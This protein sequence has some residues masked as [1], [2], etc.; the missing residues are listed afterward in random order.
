MAGLT[1]VKVEISYF[2]PSLLC[3]RGEV[4]N[5]GRSRHRAS[6]QGDWEGCSTA[7]HGWWGKA[8]F[9]KED[10]IIVKLK[11]N[12]WCF[13]YCCAAPPRVMFLSLMWLVLYGVPFLF[14]F[15]LLFS[16]FLD[17]FLCLFLLCCTVLLTAISRDLLA[18]SYDTNGYI[19]IQNFLYFLCL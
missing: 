13:I 14:S 6:A 3:L 4:L 5:W 15:L 19:V 7:R 16:F 11:N 1:P 8:E 17:H 9:T 2:K 12:F 18:F 10:T